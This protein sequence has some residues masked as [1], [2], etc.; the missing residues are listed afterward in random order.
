M[1][2]VTAAGLTE[3]AINDLGPLTIFAPNDAA[4]AQFAADRP[5]LDLDDE[6]IALAIVLAHWS[7]GEAL[8]AAALAGRT[9]L[10]MENG[11]IQ[12][13]NSATPLVI[14]GATVVGS[15][16]EAIDAIIHVVDRVLPIGL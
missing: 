8:D 9:D 3:E 16:I 15:E 2:A 6:A 4:V 7:S 12:T 11:E 14:S 1:A 13:V 5:D 10:A